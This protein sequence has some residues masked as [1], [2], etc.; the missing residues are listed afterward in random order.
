MHMKVIKLL[1]SDTAKY[2]WIECI[3]R[4]HCTLCI[5]ASGKPTTV[6]IKILAYVWAALENLLLVLAMQREVGALES[7]CGRGTCMDWGTTPHM[8]VWGLCGHT[9]GAYSVQAAE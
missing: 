8:P 1:G 6:S 2:G 5:P 7:R 4:T 9:A 3:E